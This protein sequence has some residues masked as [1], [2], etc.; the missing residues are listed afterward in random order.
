MPQFSGKFHR[1]EYEIGGG[2]G[3][4]HLRRRNIFRQEISHR[5]EVAD[6]N[7]SHA[8]PDRRKRFLSEDRQQVVVA[9]AAEKRAV[10]F[11]VFVEDLEDDAGIV[12]EPAHDARIKDDIVEAGFMKGR[13][14]CG[15]IGRRFFG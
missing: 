11:G 7:V 15:D 4:I 10:V 3:E 14:Y 9:S 5:K 12:V 8:E 2:N 6:G 13:E 1:L